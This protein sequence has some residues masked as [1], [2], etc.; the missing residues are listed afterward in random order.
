[1]KTF[2]KT[3]INI[4]VGMAMMVI[5]GLITKVYGENNKEKTVY[6]NFR[7]SNEDMQNILNFDHY[8]K[9]N[10]ADAEIYKKRGYLHFKNGNYNE[11]LIDFESAAS[12]NQSDAF[13]Y[14]L[15]S[16]TYKAM[17]KPED[18]RVYQKMAQGIMYK[19]VEN[20]RPAEYKE[21]NYSVQLGVF[22]NEPEKDFF[23][24]LDKKKI[25]TEF[26]E[27]GF[28]IYTYGQYSSY[29]EAN[30]IKQELIAKGKPGVFVKAY[31]NGEALHI[32]KAIEKENHPTEELA[33]SAK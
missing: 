7:I 6:T 24:G 31:Y 29:A 3:T 4:I 14:H 26:N 25:K 15:I 30:S 22:K 11:A 18:A 5:L 32:T 16:E 33:E 9:V 10:P 12:I 17:N 8:I 23:K 13:L 28:T 27:L 19:G 20:T 2:Y 1:M 21:L